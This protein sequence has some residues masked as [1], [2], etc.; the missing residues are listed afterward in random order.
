LLIL[1]AARR[2]FARRHRM[3][4]MIAPTIRSSTIATIIQIQKGGEESGGGGPPKIAAAEL[5]ADDERSDDDRRV[6]EEEPEVVDFDWSDEENVEAKV[7]EAD[8]ADTRMVGPV[9]AL[10]ELEVRVDD[11]SGVL[12]VAVIEVVVLREDDDELGKTQ[13]AL[14]NGLGWKQTVPFAAQT[15]KSALQMSKESVSLQLNPV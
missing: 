7:G 3:K 14:V 2:L 1:P 5:M 8:F 11:T 15:A 9:T 13:L 6:V 4:P 10:I 12:E